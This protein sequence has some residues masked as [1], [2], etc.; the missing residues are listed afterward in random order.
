MR[1][2]SLPVMGQPGNGRIRGFCVRRAPG[3]IPVMGAPG[4]G[5]IRGFCACRA[6][7]RLWAN[8]VL[9]GSGVFARA[10]RLAG[11]WRT[12]YWVHPGFLRV[13]RDI[14]V[15]GEPGIGQI[16]GFWAR[17]APRAAQ[18]PGYGRTGYWADP[19]FLRVP[20]D[21][22]VMG[23]PAIGWIRVFA[24]AARHAPRDIPVMAEPGIGRIR[25]FCACRATSRL[26]ANR[27]LGESGFLGGPRATRRATSRLWAN[28]VLGGSGVFARAAR[29]PG[30]GRTGYWVDPE[31]FSRA[32]RHPGYG[33]TGYWEDQGFLRVPRDIPVMGEPAIGWIR[34]S[35]RAACHAPR[36]IPVI[37]E[38][39]IGRIRGFYACPATSRLWANRLL[40]GSGVFARAA[41]RAARHPSY[42]RTRYW[43]DP[44]FLR[45]PRD[46]PVMGEPGIGRILGFR[47]RR[48]PRD[49]LVMGEPGIGRI[50]GFWAR[51][52]RPGYGRTGYWADPWFLRAPRALAP[53]DIP[54]IGEP[55]IGWIRGFCACR[56]TSRLWG[57]RVLGGSGVF[58][59]AARRATSRL[60]AHRILGG[61]RL[62]RDIPVMGKP[63]IERIRG[64]CARRTPRTARHPGCG[65]T[66]YWADLGFL[67]A[68]RDI[69]VMGE[70]GI[71]RIWGFCACRATSRL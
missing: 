27:L 49:I 40:G 39:G 10:A 70:P 43:A 62:P 47:A 2:A 44:W 6:T 5:R 26:W 15:M 50:R 9:G 7:S 18:H 36:D 19:G 65:R 59:R 23:E 64:F 32:A 53:R 69:P 28:G 13:P 60:W 45:V 67:R 12:G 34:V 11:Y 29:H 66:G 25:G 37:G 71:G 55:G 24:R 4:I 51:A 3:D 57:N 54:V 16:W 63:R 68:P 41:P 38:P 46:I 58:G 48:A 17:R 52:R 31:F 14:P 56:A 21:I 30:Y 42:G 20:R 8:Q 1:R 33:R 35:A 22:P 61:L